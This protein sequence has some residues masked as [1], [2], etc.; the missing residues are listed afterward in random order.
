MLNNCPYCH[1]DI[2]DPYRTPTSTSV[3]EIPK[4]LRWYNKINWTWYK[5]MDWYR[6]F[7][8]L[9]TYTFYLFTLILASGLIG[10][11]AYSFYKS[12]TV[13]NKVDFCYVAK[14]GD[15]NTWNLKGNIEWGEDRNFGTFSTAAGAADYADEINCPLDITPK[16]KPITSS[17]ASA[18][19]SVA[20]PI[21]SAQ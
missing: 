11:G 10:F 16:T 5:E 13:P 1:K 8:N 21:T 17:S 4:K 14:S 19:S 9:R 18:A 12:I 3:A 6:F 15:Y 7:N 2:S 20:A